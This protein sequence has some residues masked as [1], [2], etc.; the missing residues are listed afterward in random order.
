MLLT[1][2]VFGL[3]FVG[4]FDGFCSMPRDGMSPLQ[5][6]FDGVMAQTL[7]RS[8]YAMAQNETQLIKLLFIEL[9]VG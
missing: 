4:A 6:L 9:K 5:M 8:I 1:I 7:T 3:Q 2:G